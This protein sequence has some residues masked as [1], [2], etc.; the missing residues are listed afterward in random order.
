LYTSEGR[1][2]IDG[3]S[4]SMN[5]NLGHGNVAV[6]AAMHEQALGLTSL[7]SIAG[8]VSEASIALADRLTCIL[9][10]PDSAC[11][12]TSSGSEATE[13]ALAS[14]WK[15]WSDMRRPEKYR[16]LSL[17]GSYHG[18][19][20]GALAL[21]GRAEEHVDI[22]ATAPNFRLP[23]PAWDLRNP[24]CVSG[25]L[26]RVLASERPERIAAIFLEPVMGLA[27]M[28][29]A[30]ENDIRK[31][32]EICR[33]ND[34]LVVLDEALTGLGRAGHVTAARLYGIEPDS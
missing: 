8:D 13:A 3:L 33:V 6:A 7:P 19:T 21:T 24:S 5:A 28:V 16:I 30:P 12:F 14:V 31:V 22:A 18:C 29:P 27:G 34:I 17:D 25:S 4:G 32:V 10:L 11:V 2:V 15:Y 1:E 20:L 26:E 9:G 23:L